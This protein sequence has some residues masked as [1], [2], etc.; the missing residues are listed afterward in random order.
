[1]E[2]FQKEVKMR[3]ITVIIYDN[4]N[5][6]LPPVQKTWEKISN[7]ANFKIKPNIIWISG[8]LIPTTSEKLSK[9]NIN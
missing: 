9:I 1:M 3:E 5:K 4:N 8:W 6:T 7:G 2:R